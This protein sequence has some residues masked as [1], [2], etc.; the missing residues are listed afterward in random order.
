MPAL[1]YINR[2]APRGPQGLTS[3]ANGGISINSTMSSQQMHCDAIYDLTIN[4]LEQKQPP[5]HFRCVRG[6]DILFATAT[7]CELNLVLHTHIIA[8]R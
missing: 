7:V 5:P 1:I 4:I 2:K 3:P 6:S 8:I